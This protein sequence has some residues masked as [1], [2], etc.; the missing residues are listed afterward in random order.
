M[1]QEPASRPFRAYSPCPVPVR[2]AAQPSG[3][4]GG[5][6]GWLT[7]C[8]SICL[9]ACFLALAALFSPAWAEDEYQRAGLTAAEQAWLERN[10]EITLG[11]TLDFPPAVT[12]QADGQWVGLIPDYLALL[13]R[14]LDTN[15]Q[16]RV[17]PWAEVVQMAEQGLLDGLAATAPVRE[18]QETFLFS[19]P[20]SQTYYSIYTRIGDEDRFRG[21]ADLQGRRVG[22]IDRADRIAELLADHPDIAPVPLQDLENLVE[23]LLSQQVDAVVAAGYLEY[24]RR[25]NL[26]AG[27]TIAGII[28]ESRSDVVFSVHADRPE[29]LAILNKGFAAIRPEEIRT[30]QQRWLGRASSPAPSDLDLTPE[31]RDWVARNP[32][33]TAGGTDNPP[34]FMQGRDGR[35]TG[36]LSDF[37]RLIAS[38]AG[39]EPR[40]HYAPLLDLLHMAE[41][42]DLDMLLSMFWT[43]QRAE[44]FIFSEHKARLSMAIFARR[45]DA[46]IRSLDSLHGRR[47]ASTEGFA[48]QGYLQDALPDAEF[49]VARDTTQMLQMVN[50]GQA[51]AAVYD[52]HSGTYIFRR[53]FFNNLEVK[54]FAEFEALSDLYG[55]AYMV[56]KDRDLLASVLHKAYLS[57]DESEKQQIW[58]R[59]FGRQDGPRQAFSREEHEWLGRRQVLRYGYDPAWAPVEFSGPDG[60]HQGIT[61]AYL[62]RLEDLLNIRFEPV[63]FPTWSRAE[64]A[65]RDGEVDLLPAM[66]GTPQRQRDLL[67]TDPYLSMPVAIFSQ[68][69]AAY[70]GNLQALSGKKTAVV[71]DHASHK[72]LQEDYSHL[73]LVPAENVQAALRLVARDQVFAYVGNLVTTSYYIG[74]TGLTNI[75]VAGETPYAYNLAMAVHRDQ[76][77]L[78]SILQKGLDGIPQWERDAIYNDWISIRY[79]HEVDRTLLWQVLGAAATLLLMF[80][81]WNRRLAREVAWRKEAQAGLRQKQQELEAARDQAQKA[82]QIKSEFLA[83]MSHEIRTPMNGILGMAGLLLETTLSP[84]QQRYARHIR[85][86]GQLLLSI[87]ND[88]LDLSKIEAGR[89]EVRARDFDLGEMLRNCASG[90]VEAVRAKG[91]AFSCQADPDVPLHLRGDSQLLTQILNNLISNAVKFTEQGEVAVRVQKAEGNAG[92]LECRDAGIDTAESGKRKAGRET[93]DRLTVPPSHCP[94]VL[95]RFTVR[96]T[97]PGIPEDKQHLLFDNFF[98]VDSSA[99]RR[100]PGTGLGLAISR[101]LTELMG[102]RITVSSVPDQ[103]TTFSVL[104]NLEPA[105]GDLDAAREAVPPDTLASRLEEIRGARILLAEDNEINLELAV[106]HLR[107]A[108]MVVDEVRTGHEAVQ[109]AARTAYD[110]ILMDIQMP[111]MDGLEAVRRIREAEVHGSRFNGSA[112][113]A[114]EDGAKPENRTSPTV[115]REPMN[116]EPLR[117]Q[118]PIIALT[119]HGM[120]GDRE[121]SLAAGMD[122]HLTKPIQP[123]ELLQA[124]V[125]WI[126]PGHRPDPRWPSRAVPGDLSL[127]DAPNIPDIPE[128]PG[129]DVPAALARAL[130]NRELYRKL[131]TRFSARHAHFPEE[132][133]RQLGEGLWEDVRRSAHTLKGA[134]ANL[135][136]DDLAQAAEEIQVV[137]DDPAPDRAALDQALNGLRPRLAAVLAGLP[138]LVADLEP[139]SPSSGAPGTEPGPEPAAGPRPAR[140]SMPDQADQPDPQSLARALTLARSTL[141]LLDQDHLRAQAS[142]T[143]IL[144]LPLPASLLDLA[145]QAL[146]F[147]DDFDFDPA[148]HAL[149]T[150]EARLQEAIER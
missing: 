22:Y 147:L 121:K 105:W 89:Q 94:T 84:L 81:F 125:D 122:E 124:L 25:Q 116:L 128:A 33:F 139:G 83:N 75:R 87:V 97:G 120:T 113:D 17:G 19:D 100:H 137:L 34:Y 9:L 123:H 41:T 112:V 56:R 114:G 85:H 103:G 119:A 20:L 68:T 10:P 98:Q 73:E 21:L 7:A 50:S 108:G 130:G 131:L 36:Y 109:A 6:I 99:S 141:D 142:L 115:N 69:Q 149:Q 64:Q 30:I 72:W 52:L 126:L 106:A 118:P 96:D 15:I 82:N 61:S 132:L 143:V 127:S 59:W 88:I 102:G 58:E 66:A 111:E 140:T 65:L 46:G 24:W 26:V 77:E 145:G 63:A 62:D 79:A 54:G 8:L 18:R 5:T 67:F 80:T 71:Q 133:E 42:G 27:L 76:P 37:I 134:A 44:K 91:L 150:L 146:E 12:G 35:K 4:V 2:G 78:R 104:L 95:L 51:D 55:H 32:V 148:R 136:M 107:K 29:L 129:I 93:S 14:E 3:P 86:S 1:K 117:R 60:S 13:N 110:L 101:K 40:F 39:L 57:L 92:M 28:P 31:E 53:N 48:V 45:D 138:R 43:P 16:L 144:S 23:A 11:C 90:A 74:A 38:R 47:I 49:I 70:L 135:G